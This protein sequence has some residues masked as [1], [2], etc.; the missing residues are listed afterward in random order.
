MTTQDSQLV[1]MSGF[2][3]GSMTDT[4]FRTLV[5]MKASGGK[6]WSGRGGDAT[7][8]TFRAL[9]RRGLVCF[10]HLAAFDALWLLSK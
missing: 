9:E 8:S 4:C 10:H 7:A 1:T 6:G 3:F 2:S 5:G